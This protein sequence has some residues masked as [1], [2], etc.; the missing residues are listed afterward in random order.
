MAYCNVSDVRVLTGVTEAMLGDDEVEALIAFSEVQIED[1]LGVQSEPAPTRIR[2][3]YALLTAIKI[4]ARPDFRQGFHIGS[5]SY[6][7]SG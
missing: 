1:D 4:Y 2:H 3:L 5:N 7:G 6:R